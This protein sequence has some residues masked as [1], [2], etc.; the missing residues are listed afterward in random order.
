[1]EGAGW[2]GTK[3]FKGRK[4]RNGKRVREEESAAG[5]ERVNRRRCME[6]GICGTRSKDRLGGSEESGLGGGGVK[7]KGTSRANGGRL[8][9]ETNI[10]PE[11]PSPP[12]RQP[13]PRRHR[14]SSAALAPTP[15]KTAS[16]NFV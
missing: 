16:Q 5:E 4:S 3:E 8:E 12:S 7:R 6:R 9:A 13:P 14:R 15:A 2:E 10:V 11:W 1:M